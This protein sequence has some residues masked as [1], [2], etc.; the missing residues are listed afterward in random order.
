MQDISVKEE[1]KEKR[2]EKKTE[3]GRKQGTNELLE[4]EEFLNLG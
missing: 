4:I 2:K 1:E 3:E